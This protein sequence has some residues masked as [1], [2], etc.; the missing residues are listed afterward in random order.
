MAKNCQ[1]EYQWFCFSFL[2]SKKTKMMYECCVIN[3]PCERQGNMLKGNDNDDGDG[4]VLT[5]AATKIQETR[6][7]QLLLIMLW[8]PNKFATLKTTEHF[9]TIDTTCTYCIL[10]QTCI[11]F[12]IIGGSLYTG[13]GGAAVSCICMCYCIFRFQKHVIVSNHHIW[14]F[15]NRTLVYRLLLWSLEALKTNWCPLRD[16]TNIDMKDCSSVPII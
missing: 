3:T 15:S 14:F 16:E 1:I 2:F 10:Y 7:S 6:C 11:V 12:W 9:T 5:A 13:V 8:L 4:D